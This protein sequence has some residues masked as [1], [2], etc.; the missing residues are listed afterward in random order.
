MKGHTLIQGETITKKEKYNDELLKKGEII[1]EHPKYI[2]EFL[3]SC[4]QESQGQFQPNLKQSILWRRGF[5][6]IQ[7]KDPT[8]FQGE[9]ITKKQKY[10]GEL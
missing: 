3:K 4:S 10:V 5:K 2:D 6:F 8:L 7:M 1:M 9:M